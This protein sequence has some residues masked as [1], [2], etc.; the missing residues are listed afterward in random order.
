MARKAKIRKRSRSPTTK[1]KRKGL[2]KSKMQK[3]IPSTPISKSG[4]VAKST[5]NRTA[6]RGI[7]SRRASEDDHKYRVVRIMGQGQYKLDSATVDEL[8]KIDNTIVKLI[9]NKETK[10]ETGDLESRFREKLADMV[11]LVASKGKQ[12]DVKEIIT[13]DFILPPVDASIE[14]ARALFKGEGIIP[15]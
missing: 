2:G 4:R 6:S 1:S 15:E 8:N 3:S 7:A 10:N 13:S 12:L 5:I 14:E 11:S 9:E